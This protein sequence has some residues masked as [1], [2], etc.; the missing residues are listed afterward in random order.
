M[1][2][3]PSD[4][5]NDLNFEFNDEDYN[6]AYEESGN[7]SNDLALFSRPD[8][9]YLDDINLKSKQ[10]Q[11]GQ[12]NQ[13]IDPLISNDS[14]ESSKKL[15]PGANN[16]TNIAPTPNGSTTSPNTSMGPETPLTP[17][18]NVD[19]DSSEYKRK[20]N[21]AASARFRIKKKLKEQQ[22]EARAKELQEKVNSLEKRVMTLEMEKK[23]LKSMI[24]KKNEES[25]D[26][27][28]DSIKKRSITDSESFFE[29][30][31]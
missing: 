25:N 22:M 3:E 21:T 9:F 12:N 19:I 11:E 4:Y 16:T 7:N 24:L 18:L 20:R 30:T 29:Y 14:Y 5:L 23:C 17:G 6:L 27:L 1:K 2:F 15:V 28:L 31:K 13:F 10:P 8:F 26:K